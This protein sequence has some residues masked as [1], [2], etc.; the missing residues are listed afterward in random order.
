MKKRVA[1][2]KNW[3]EVTPQ[4]EDMYKI[5]QEAP[6]KIAQP[7]GPRKKRKRLV[8]GELGGPRNQEMMWEGK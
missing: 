3:L 7:G 2:R 4:K 8:R 1:E 5:S 6:P